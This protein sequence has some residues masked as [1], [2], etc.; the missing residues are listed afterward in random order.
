MSI[1][2]CHIINKKLIKKKVIEFSQ[3]YNL[4][5]GLGDR[6]GSIKIIIVS[7]FFLK[8]GFDQVDQVIDAPVK[9]T[10][11]YRINYY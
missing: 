5:H 7:I 10:K 4:G 11:S 1:F 3:A 8:L 2:Y 6:P 9:L